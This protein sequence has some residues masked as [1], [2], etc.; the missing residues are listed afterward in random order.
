MRPRDRLSPET[1]EIR[2]ANEYWADTELARRAT[3]CSFQRGLYRSSSCHTT[4]SHNYMKIKPRRHESWNYKVNLFSLSFAFRNPKYVR[5]ISDP[6]PRFL[7]QQKYFILLRLRYP[8]N[9]SPRIFLIFCTYH[10]LY[11]EY[12]SK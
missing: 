4:V 7:S 2:D 1:I 6:P 3:P 10:F 9:I 8:R 12:V 11:T 5:A